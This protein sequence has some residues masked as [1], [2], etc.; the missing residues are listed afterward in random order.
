MTKTYIA[1]AIPYV[2]GAP[3]VGHAMDFLIADTYRRFLLAQ[4]DEVRL[5]AGTDEHGNKVF[6]KAEQEGVPVQQFVDKNAAQFKEFI[7]RLGVEYTDFIRT[8][9]EDH[10]RRCQLIWKQLEPYIYKDTYE[11]WY[12]EGCE[13]FVT[14]TEYDA[15]N[16]VCPDH[17]K[18]YIKLSEEN[19]YLRLS[20]FTDRIK[21]AIE[22]DEMRIVPESR[23]KEFLNLLADVADVSI[24]RPS[25]Q[26]SWGIP[27]PGDDTQVMYVWVDALANYI[28]VLG[29][30]EED[31]SDWWPAKVQVIGK[32]ILRFHAGIW[33]AILLGV[34]L[35][36]PH[37]LLTH[38]HITVDGA[39]MS[40]SVGNV[41]DPIEILDKHGTEPFRYYFL[42]HV[43]TT[44]DADFSWEKFE[45]A[46]NELANDL[47]NLVQR[48]S[49]MCQKYSIA[50]QG[51]S[52]GQTSD[53]RYEDLM[54]NFEFSNAFNH[55]WSKIQDINKAIDD[56]KP[57]EIAKTGDQAKLQSTLS[58][59][60][61]DLLSASQL[62]A[63]FLP[64]TSK[65][66]DDIFTAAKITPP[67]TSL[68]PKA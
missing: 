36:L 7:H 67:A 6:K 31:I 50:G 56:A 21:E 23:K 11:G 63:P 32:D 16:G 18:P 34:N 27:V 14:Q 42:R 19:Y 38:G 35:P 15:N 25:K 12:C 58:D 47:G 39:K 20:D 54:R 62:L 28:T 48:L 53:N 26:L 45:S 5:Q 43:P 10:I 33:P 8:T 13:G 30:P 51:L 66:I 57:W 64:E 29:F 60:V 65:K 1:T 2:N 49:T 4:G 37:T 68:F 17:Q 59:M 41:I 9:D 24:S 61:K 46:Y 22:T 55:V 52:A 44:E 40:K 3:H